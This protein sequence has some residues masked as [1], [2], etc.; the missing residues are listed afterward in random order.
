[1]LDKGTEGVMVFEPALVKIAPGDTVKFVATNKGHNAETIK[2]MLPE[3]ADAVRRQ[4]EPGDRR[5]V[6]QARASTA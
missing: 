4:G 6:R 5:H 2:G 1:M 3:G